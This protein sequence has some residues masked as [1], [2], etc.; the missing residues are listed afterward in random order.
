MYRLITAKT[1]GASKILILWSES[2]L[3]SG[4]HLALFCFASCSIKII[5]SALTKFL[6]VILMKHCQRYYPK[7]K[8]AAAS[9]LMERDIKFFMQLYLNLVEVGQ[10]L[11]AD[12]KLCTVTTWRLL[13]RADYILWNG[14]QPYYENEPNEA[15]VWSHTLSKA[16][17]NPDTKWK[18]VFSIDNGKENFAFQ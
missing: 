1:W 9:S 18:R 13:F 12:Q 7:P 5:N 3:A 4:R 6:K 10:I 14:S 8:T 15:R 11:S 16:F 17:R 2:G